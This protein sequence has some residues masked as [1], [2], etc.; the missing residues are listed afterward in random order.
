MHCWNGNPGH[1]VGSTPAG[2]LA[3]VGLWAALLS[4]MGKPGQRARSTP[5]GAVPVAERMA[6]FVAQNGKLG[7]ARGS[8]PAG[9]TCCWGWG[10]AWVLPV[11]RARERRALERNIFF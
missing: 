2:N 6:E 8:M 4:Q 11:A 3:W 5:A 7:H 9:N 10:K 1:L